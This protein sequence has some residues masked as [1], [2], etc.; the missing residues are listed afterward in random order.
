[1]LHLEQAGTALLTGLWTPLVV[2]LITAAASVTIALA[3]VRADDL[4]RAE[5]LGQVLAQ[6]DPSPEREVVSTVRDDL[7]VAWALR[8]AAPVDRRMRRAAVVLGVLGAVALFG[9]IMV[10]LYV[11]LGY[12]RVSDWF[13]WVYYSAGLALLLGSALLRRF[14]RRH[15]DA[16]IAEERARRGLRPALHTGVASERTPKASGESAPS[17]DRPAD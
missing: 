5:R 13:F 9:A 7:A 1:M 4:R 15:A 12:G 17:S 10:G 3:N 11:G 2:A 6:M 8:E 14:A 16:W